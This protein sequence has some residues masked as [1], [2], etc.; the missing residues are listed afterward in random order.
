MRIMRVT[1][2]AVSL[3]ALP[4]PA[5]AASPGTPDSSTRPASRVWVTGASNLRRF[6]CRAQ[7]VA[8]ALALQANAT[9][10]S[11]L[12]G[13]NVSSEPSLSIPLDRLDCGVGVMNHHLRDALRGSTYPVVE[14]RLGTYE[15]D[16]TAM[17]P[18]ARI[19]G[20]LTIGGVERPVAVTASVR[21]DSSGALHVRGTYTVR[22]REFGIEPPRRFG[23]LLRV[24]DHVTVHFDV[25]P[26]GD[27]DA[28]KVIRCSMTPPAHAATH[29]ENAS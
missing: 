8:G 9:R 4:A 24:R 2:L 29:T 13:E 10:T 15:V 6:T 22:L 12:S 14:F 7:Q 25:A 23:G 20:R 3:L 28:V 5:R 19:A 27:D 17:T 18:V 11:V 1:W 21:T 16:L 26:D